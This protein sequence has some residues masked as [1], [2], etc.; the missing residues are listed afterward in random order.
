[1]AQWLRIHLPKQELQ[2]TQV[3]SL[4]GENPLEEEMAINSNILDRAPWRATVYAVTKS[5][6]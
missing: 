6:T 5:W 1:M 4:D 2:E 3:Q